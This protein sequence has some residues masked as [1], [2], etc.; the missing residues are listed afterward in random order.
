[1]DRL[2]LSWDE[3][4]RIPVEELPDH[5]RVPVRIMPSAGELFS[6]L[7]RYTAD[8]IRDSN[9]SPT[10]LRIVWPCGPKRHFPLLAEICNREGISWRNT[11]NIQ[12]DEWLDWQCR[13]L[14][15]DHL[16]NLQSYL[17]RELFERLDAALRPTED[18]MVFH[19]PLHMGQVDEKL[20]E[21]GG[22]DVVFGG[23]GFT[24]HFAYNEPPTSRWIH[25]SNEEFRSSRTHIVATN[26]ETFI[27]H[28]HRS[29]GGNTRPIP[30]MGAT[31]GMKDLLGAKRIRLVSDGGAWKQ[32]IFRVLCMHEPTVRYPCTFVQGHPDV[33][34]IVDAKTAACPP[35][36]FD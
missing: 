1:M 20:D 19:D 14:P 6:Y 8:L 31:L 10:P 9:T 28:A 15:A 34:V 25:I 16:L 26:D 32:T 35:N 13:P 7:A 11:V 17:R 30:P 23:F 4:L 18:Q 22:I 12:M 36:C 29:T 24:G 21:L 5:S 33:E 2:R 27:M 3:M